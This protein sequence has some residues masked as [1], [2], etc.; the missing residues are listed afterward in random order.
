MHTSTTT[1]KGFTLV[2][3]LVA[4]FLLSVAVASSMTMIQKSLQSSIYSKDEITASFLAQD[5]I[6]YIH[7]LRDTN[8]LRIAHC[9]DNPGDPGC[10]PTPTWL[11]GLENCDN[12]HCTI[13][14]TD[15][16]V[17]PCISTCTA[18]LRYNQ[19]SRFYTYAA[20]A[21]S[22]PSKFVRDVIITDINDGDVDEVDNEIKVRVTMS[23]RAGAGTQQIVVTEHLLNRY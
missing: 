2:E 1:K 20:A 21:N 11:D 6:E 16:T 5:V 17:T 9:T 3:T 7:N 10:S 18:V 23:W 4:V 13:D 14:T 8:Y 22:S 12:N 15:D 19:T